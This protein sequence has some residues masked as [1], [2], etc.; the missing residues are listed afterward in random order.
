[1]LELTPRQAVEQVQTRLALSDGELAH[2]LSTSLRTLHRWRS[3]TSYPQHEARERLAALVKIAEHLTETFETFEASYIWM[4]TDNRYLGGWKPADAIRLGRFD[5][6]EAALDAL[7]A[8]V[9]V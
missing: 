7:D 8:G 4:N 9:F 5:R 2:A 3:N 6:V 1:M